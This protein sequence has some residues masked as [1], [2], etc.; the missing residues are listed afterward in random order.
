MGT[1]AR[2]SGRDGSHR[3]LVALFG[4]ASCGRAGQYAAD[5]LNRRTARGYPAD[6]LHD[7]AAVEFERIGA[8]NLVRV[9]LGVDLTTFGVRPRSA[10]AGQLLLVR[11]GCPRKRSRSGR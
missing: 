4:L 3:S 8:R 10:P 9:P 6:H 7:W 5:W 2:R 1:Q 11:C